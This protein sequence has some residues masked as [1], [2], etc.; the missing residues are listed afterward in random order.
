[1][2]SDVIQPTELDRLLVSIRKIIRAEFPQLTYM[3]FWEYAVSATDGTT[4]DCSPT[5]TAIPLPALAKVPLISGL[6]GELATPVVGKKC[7]ILFLNG[8]PTKARCISIDGA[9]ER[10]MTVE[11]V[12]LMFY[13]VFW[14]LTNSPT[15]G[16]TGPWTGA[17]LQPFLVAAINA[18]LGVQATP[19]LPGVLP[20]Q[21]ANAALTAG[22]T[23]GSVPSNALGPLATGLSAVPP[24]TPN[25]SGLFPGVGA[26]K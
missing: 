3:G 22:M 2:S 6:L 17:S 4:I 11:A 7:V 10:A 1:M 8:D 18:A 23:A 15:T 14:A 9:N 25:V 26:T 24:K 21:A 16:P 20:Q 5:D 12:S 13:N 19:A